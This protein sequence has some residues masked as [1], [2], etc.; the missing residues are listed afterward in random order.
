MKT[1][2]VTGASSGIGF[3]TCELLAAKGLKVYGAARRVDRME[4]LRAKGTDTLR[5]D[6]TSE[7]S[8]VE[9]VQTILADAGRI[10]VLVNNAGYG[11]LG[12]MET[13]SMENAREQ[14][15]VNL[16]G[17]ARLTQLVLPAMRKQGSGRII[18][19][20]SIAGK[21]PLPFCSWYNVSKFSIE[22]LAEDLSM[23]VASQGI[24]ISIIEP[25]AI[26][27]AWG[28]IAADNLE[29]SSGGTPY[30]KAASAVAAL[31]RKYY[32]S[33]ALPG[34]E[35]VARTIVRAACSQHPC[36]RYHTGAL[37][38]AAPLMRH[39]LP[40]KWW[41]RILMKGAGIE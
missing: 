18:F 5:L 32:T 3:A 34:P 6:V 10:D 29:K 1:A 31:T 41:D 11:E 24:R 35:T 38:V 17:A 19:V 33:N 21:I 7:E 4:P 9:V 40:A 22:A 30:E 36:L 2:L 12:P 23:E 28:T 25:G 37:G 8:M 39:I 27:T 16:F 14:L 26:G 20:S 15:E 13:V